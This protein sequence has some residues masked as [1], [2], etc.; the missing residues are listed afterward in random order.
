M[1]RR[2][3]ALL[4]VNCFYK[5]FT[6]LQEHFLYFIRSLKNALAIIQYLEYL[7]EII[8]IPNTLRKRTSGLSIDLLDQLFI[9]NTLSY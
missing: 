4:N 7:N 9:S 1:F 6:L 2:F 5:F 8:Y 3:H